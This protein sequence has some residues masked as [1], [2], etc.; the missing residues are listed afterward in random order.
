MGICNI[1][2]LKFKEDS[3][4]YNLKQLQFVVEFDQDFAAAYKTNNRIPEQIARKLASLNKVDL[5][6]F[7]E[8]FNAQIAEK[9]AGCF[10]GK[11]QVLFKNS[12]LLFVAENGE[13]DFS[14]TKD[15][16]VI[17]DHF[18]NSWDDIYPIAK[19]VNSAA[20]YKFNSKNGFI[21][22][23]GDTN[24]KVKSENSNLYFSH[25]D[26]TKDIAT[27]LNNSPEYMI[28][29]GGV[30]IDGTYLLARSEEKCREEAEVMKKTGLKIIVDLCREIN[31]YP[32]LTWLSEIEHSYE[33]TTLIQ[34]NIL[35][36]MELMGIKQVIISSHMRP[37]QWRP[38]IKRSQEES[39]I[40]G[41]SEF[42]KK[43]NESG[44]TVSIQNA[45]YKH[46]PSR[47]LA[48]PDEVI[49]L[50]TDLKTK[51][52]NV[53]FAANLGFGDNLIKLTTG[54]KDNLNI[55]IIAAEGSNL[56]D[57]RVPFSKTGNIVKF[58]IDKNVMVVFD[59][60]Y[61]NV[62]ELI[63]EKSFIQSGINKY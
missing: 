10:S 58:D 31:N 40:S 16:P 46:Y 34:Q 9:I 24:F 13:V 38:D 17:I 62:N 23:T 26:F 56:Y 43:A 20:R 59:A 60:D 7:P 54:G 51:Y 49:R 45:M 41:I 36:K 39:I 11:P 8:D 48:K 6:V 14:K 28:H 32:N 30:K 12:D 50:V 47:L 27:V 53:K 18:Y 22:N 21:E 52:S 5:L 57:Y 61:K 63:D 3:W 42:I 1:D 4:W 35:K 55:C 29:F 44:I 37:E 15:A 25:H 2:S 19:A 33:R